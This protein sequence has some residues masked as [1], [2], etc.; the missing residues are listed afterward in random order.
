MAKKKSFP[1]S[2]DLIFISSVS[3]TY[4]FK[5]AAL[6]GSFYKRGPIKILPRYRA[7]LVRPTILNALCFRRALQNGASLKNPKCEGTLWVKD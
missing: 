1:L 4:L 2:G 3:L 5:Y 7:G 6:W